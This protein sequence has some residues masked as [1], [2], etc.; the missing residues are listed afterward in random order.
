MN[1]LAKINLNKVVEGLGPF[2]SALLLLVM[3]AVCLYSGYRMG[4]FFHDYQMDTL[5]LQSK[6]LKIFYQHEEEQI[7]RIHILET[8]LAVERLSNQRSLKLIAEM[9]RQ[10]YQVKKDLAFYEKVMA[11]EKQANG[12]VIDNFT[13]TATQSPRHFRFQVTLVQQLLKK[14]YAKGYVEL[15]FTGSLAKKPHKFPLTKI[16]SLSKKELTFNFQYFQIVGGEFTLPE[17]FSPENTNVSVILPKS[18]WQKY[19]Q[20]DESFPWQKAGAN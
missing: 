3:V 13:I 7:R 4:N 9:E 11:P 18:K 16:S 1:W 15:V 19:R 14:R 6:R 10:H 8:E 17:G 12:L 2:R 20:I 5:S